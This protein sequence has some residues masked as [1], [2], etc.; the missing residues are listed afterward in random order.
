MDAIKP[1]QP[2]PELRVETLGG[3]IWKV[4][5]QQPKNFTLVVFYRGYHCPICKPYLRDLHSK[6]AQFAELGVDVI[7]ISSDTRERAEKTRKEWEIN[8][9]RIGYGLSLDTAREWGLF[10][11]HAIRDS[12]PAQF[13]EP[14]LFLIRPDGT[15]Y[16]AAIQTMPFARPRFDELLGALKFIIE[17]DYPARGEA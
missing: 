9:L 17:N 5:Q 13:S 1:G 6:L 15:L 4:S 7:A 8:H 12:E 16:A 3:N 10:V 14:G 11:S 2:V